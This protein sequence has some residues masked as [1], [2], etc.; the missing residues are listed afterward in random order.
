MACNWKIIVEQGRVI[1]HVGHS[2]MPK[3]L[4]RS[5]SVISLANTGDTVKNLINALLP[6]GACRKHQ[7]PQ[8]S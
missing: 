5:S 4:P 7:Y 2:V 6:R 8:I 1:Q 3:P